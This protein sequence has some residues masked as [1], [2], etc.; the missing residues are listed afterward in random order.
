MKNNK[1]EEKERK[2]K[3]MAILTAECDRMFAVAE[4]Q[5]TLF[6]A[7][8]GNKKNREKA[9]DIVS[10]LAKKIIVEGNTSSDDNA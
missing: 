3:K 9:D 8:K 4:D 10:K 6:K 1:K 2:E 7:Q 5:V